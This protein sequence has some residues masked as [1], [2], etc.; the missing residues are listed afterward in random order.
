MPTYEYNCNNCGH[1]QEALQKF[2][3]APLTICENCREPSLKRGFGGGLGFSFQGSG[4]YITDYASNG[5]V[6]E[7]KEVKECCPCGKNK[8]ACSAN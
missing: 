1:K 5:A 8:G 2:S 7:K 6:S 3:D 4:F